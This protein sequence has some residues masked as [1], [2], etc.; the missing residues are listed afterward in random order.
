MSDGLTLRNKPKKVDAPRGRRQYGVKVA[1]A[2]LLV[3]AIVFVLSS[4]VFLTGMLGV[5]RALLL[6]MPPPFELGGNMKLQRFYDVARDITSLGSPEVVCLLG[7]TV[8]GYFLSTRRFDRALTL[9]LSLGGGI[10]LAV[11]LKAVFGVLRPHH[12][13]DGSMANTSFPSGH[14]MMASLFFLTLA[15]LWLGRARPQLEKMFVLAAAI[16]ISFVVGISRL[17][18]GIHWPSDVLAG[19]AV[20]VGWASL[21]WITIAFRSA[22]T[23]T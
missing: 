5:E 20:G 13:A 14:A 4:T 12:A 18:L 22:R 16:A 7:L 2:A 8:V 3:A 6:G 10:L 19:W 23:R 21:V 11:L 17:Y 9:T 15:A 1:A